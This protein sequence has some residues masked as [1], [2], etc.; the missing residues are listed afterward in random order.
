M[1]T[2]LQRRFVDYLIFSRC[3]NTEAARKAGYHDGAGLRV[4]A[5]RLMNRPDVQSYLK[6]RVAEELSLHAARAVSTLS[7]LSTEAMSERVQLD[8]SRDILDRAGFSKKKTNVTI[9]PTQGIN[10][11]IDL[12]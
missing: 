5:S 6:Q 4:T 8:A 2:D 11:S 10:V 3:S 1:L 9:Q 7:S 12:E